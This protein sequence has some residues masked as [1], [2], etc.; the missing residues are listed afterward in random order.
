MDMTITQNRA[1]ASRKWYT[2]EVIRQVRVVPQDYNAPFDGDAGGVQVTG[3]AFNNKELQSVLNHPFHGPHLPWR[4]YYRSL[5]NGYWIRT[6]GVVTLD[7]NR[8]VELDESNRAYRGFMARPYDQNT[9][10]TWGVKYEYVIEIL[11]WVSTHWPSEDVR[12]HAII[13]DQNNGGSQTTKSMLADY[14]NMACHVLARVA[15][16]P[17]PLG[18]NGRRSN[19]TLKTLSEPTPTAFVEDFDALFNKR[20]DIHYN[21]VV[22]A[23][24][25]AMEIF[26]GVHPKAFNFDSIMNRKI[27]NTNDHFMGKTQRGIWS[28]DF[29]KAMMTQD[30]I[31]THPQKYNLCKGGYY[32]HLRVMSLFFPINK[33]HADG[34]KYCSEEDFA[35]I[36][37]NINANLTSLIND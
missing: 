8:M 11:H 36:G 14:L 2:P 7:A 20:Q 13:T 4:R 15:Y 33:D 31:R 32:P 19:A 35:L 25:F 12:E 30:E 5:K 21:F 1:D 9:Q 22:P 26:N 34:R 3:F 23:L 28:Y 6:G 10:V 18:R 17:I 16:G 24:F 29:I 27:C 37:E